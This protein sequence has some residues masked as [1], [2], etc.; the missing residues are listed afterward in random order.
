M[1]ASLQEQGQKI[2]LRPATEADTEFLN[3]L[4]RSVREPELLAMDWTEAQI[5]D[6]CAIQY[7]SRTAGYGQYLPPVES[8]VVLL[9][10]EP[11]G[12]LDVSRNPGDWMLANIELM[13]GARG[14]GLGTRLLT[15]L[16][17]DARQAGAKLRLRVATDSP[18]LRLCLRCGF[19]RAADDGSVQQMEWPPARRRHGKTAAEAQ[20]LS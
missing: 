9:G 14:Q 17:G 11:V 6:F 7:R 18:A 15:G 8:S 5:Q 20:R 1:G 16:Q 2:A 19:G 12:R 4:Y 13:P 10:H 3:T